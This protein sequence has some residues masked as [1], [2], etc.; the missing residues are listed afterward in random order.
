M[1]IE[2]PKN[3]KREK[4][5]TIEESMKVCKDIYDKALVLNVDKGIMT[6]KHLTYEVEKLN[7]VI[8]ANMP[9]VLAMLKDMQEKKEE[10]NE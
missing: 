9:T 1:L 7:K 5:S 4:I 6:P 10:E 8:L 3:Y 2:R